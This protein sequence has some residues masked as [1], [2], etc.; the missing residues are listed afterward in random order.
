MAN[1]SYDEAVD[2]IVEYSK[3]SGFPMSDEEYENK[4]LDL[5]GIFNALDIKNRLS[6]SIE[7]NHTKKYA[8]IN[9]EVLRALHHR[10]GEK[11]AWEITEPHWKNHT[12]DIRPD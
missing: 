3:V 9:I 4:G 2:R 11:P 12:F 7:R 10:K 8:T 1:Y 6:E 5:E